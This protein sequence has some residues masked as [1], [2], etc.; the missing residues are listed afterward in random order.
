MPI[1]IGHAKKVTQ[2]FVEDEI[3]VLVTTLDA[4]SITT[5]TAYLEGRVEEIEGYENVIRR[6][7]YYGTSTSYGNDVYSTGSFA[8]GSYN[9]QITGLDA[10]T[11]YHYQA[12]VYDAYNDEH[13]GEDKTMV[14][15]KELPINMGSEAIYRWDGIGNSAGHTRILA[16]NP[17][18]NTGKI[19]KIEIW[20]QPL[21]EIM[22]GTIIAIFTQISPN[23]FTARSREIIGDVTAGSKQ[24][25]EVNLDVV[26]GDFIGFYFSTGRMGQS[27]DSGFWVIDGDQT[28]CNELTFE[29]IENKTLSLYGTNQ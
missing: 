14:T 5:T 16:D 7:F 12:Y 8:A 17:A 27:A 21:P 3:N 11:T 1:I 26:A 19:T 10:N 4:Y 18:N 20:A 24:T 29:F 15:E 22:T 23:V 13:K 9:K 2:E 6:G 25:F 28:A